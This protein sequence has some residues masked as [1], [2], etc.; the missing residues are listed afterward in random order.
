MGLLLSFYLESKS[1]DTIRY[2]L[3][4]IRIII[5]KYQIKRNRYLLSASGRHA[6]TKEKKYSSLPGINCFD[7]A[8]LFRF[9]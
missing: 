2:F 1:F 8:A 9:E 3:I 7:S 5:T 6:Q 4:R